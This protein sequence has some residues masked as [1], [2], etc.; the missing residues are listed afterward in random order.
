MFVTLKNGD[1]QKRNK[2][3]R[4]SVKKESCGL[5]TRKGISLML[6]RFWTA[7]NKNG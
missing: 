2:D 4:V 6:K 7:G 1:W 5:L 3:L